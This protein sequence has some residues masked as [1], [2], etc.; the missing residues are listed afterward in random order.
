M[1]V[2]RPT[3]NGS[4]AYIDGIPYSVDQV[5]GENAIIH[6]LNTDGTPVN[7]E[8]G[9]PVTS[10]VPIATLS[11]TPDSAQKENDSSAHQSH[12]QPAPAA[13]DNSQPATQQAALSQTETDDNELPFVI[14][15]D[16][17]TTFG[18]I[19]RRQGMKTAPIKLSIGFNKTAAD[20]KNH[21]Y[22]LEHIESTHGRQIRDAGF[23]SVPQFVEHVAKHYNSVKKGK[24]RN[25]KDTFLL[26]LTDSHNNTLFIELANDGSYWNVNSA[27]I[28]RKE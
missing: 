2:W 16:G 18:M 20:G 10:I 8:Q 22:G 5:D 15:S 23:L 27:G 11:T 6:R 1:A 25:G 24:T 28:F 21:G 17:T 14:A 4:I 9:N 12:T 7:D 26:E 3:A 13:E 19:A